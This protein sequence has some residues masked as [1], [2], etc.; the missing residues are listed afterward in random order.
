MRTVFKLQART[1]A[2]VVFAV[3]MTAAYTTAMKGPWPVPGG[4]LPSWAMAI[5]LLLV[6][7]L[8]WL[9][10]KPRDWRRRWPSALGVAGAGF[11]LG[12][13]LAPQDDALWAVLGDVR[14]LLLGVV[15]LAELWLLSGLLRHVWR[16]RQD[17]N[18]EAVA[19]RGVKQV[20]GD[21]I[22]ARLMQLESRLWVY[23]LMRPPPATSF[24]GQQHFGVHRQHGNASHQQGFVILMA[25]ELPIA[26][27]F[28][29]L[30]FGTTVAWVVTAISAYGWLYLWADYRATRWRPLS[31]DADTLHLRYG[32]LIDAA[33]PRVAV[34]G[35]EPVAARSQQGRRARAPGCLV[36]QGMGRANVRLRLQPGTRVRL[37]WGEREA[38]ELLIG[39]DEPEHFIQAING[40]AETQAQEA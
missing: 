10:L 20:F 40:P 31:L 27:L 6:L 5:D 38:L 39:V 32:L 21:G 17:G 24:A 7:P 13:W 1:L 14:W 18:A 35:A 28:V 34:L 37:P 12:R 23:A 9:L 26:H 19:A 2:F 11:L 22:S 16:A 33:L 29:H 25:A 8:A 15:L 4:P 3:L 36:L 30:A